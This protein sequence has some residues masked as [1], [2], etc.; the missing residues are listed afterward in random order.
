MVDSIKGVKKEHFEDRQI[1][2]LQEN[3]KKTIDDLRTKVKE[4][5][6]RIVVLEG[7]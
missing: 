5:E 6:E 1:L 7:P 3:L 4:L 2:K